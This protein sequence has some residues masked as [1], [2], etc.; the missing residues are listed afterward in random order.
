MSEER[1]RS[2][3]P[4]SRK[5][6]TL[7]SRPRLSSPPSSPI[8]PASTI[9]NRNA[10]STNGELTKLNENNEQ[11]AASTDKPTGVE[12]NTLSAPGLALANA[13]D[14]D[15]DIS[16]NGG[17]SAEKCAAAASAHCAPLTKHFKAKVTT[18]SLV[19]CISRPAQIPHSHIKVAHEYSSFE[20][21]VT[22]LKFTRN[23]D[24]LCCAGDHILGACSTS[25][26]RFSFILGITIFDLTYPQ[27]QTT[28]WAL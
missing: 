4:S 5:P 12:G 26:S 15:V 7:A 13:N 6:S 23:G 22:T 10:V 28:K 2:R 9:G 1:K 16:H 14:K 24:R 8:G 18:S 11:T 21:G 27:L 25:N 20:N 3:S 17:S 19:A